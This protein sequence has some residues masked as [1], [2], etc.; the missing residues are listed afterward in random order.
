MC[1]VPASQWK[2]TYTSL[3]LPIAQISLTRLSTIII[4]GDGHSS[5]SW[6]VKQ[7]KGEHAIQGLVS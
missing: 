7:T 2:G 5:K 1:Y 4:Y 6:L 3:L